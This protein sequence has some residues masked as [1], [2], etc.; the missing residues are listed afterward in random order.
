MP[1]IAFVI[2]AVV[3]LIGFLIW[4]FTR[5]KV[6]SCDRSPPR[7]GIGNGTYSVNQCTGNIAGNG[8]YAG[9]AVDAGLDPTKLCICPK[10][11]NA[12][13][14][15]DPIR[16]PETGWYQWFYDGQPT[17]IGGWGVG[18]HACVDHVVCSD[19][20]FAQLDGELPSTSSTFGNVAK[21]MRAVARVV[22]D[23][24]NPYCPVQYS[25][26]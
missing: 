2:G 18:G 19:D 3:V 14:N 22:A 1:R 13:A 7:D 5:L 4:Y 8:W 12:P 24:A 25:V 15:I 6:D 26:S 11:L 10:T 21:Q 9:P 23:G 20:F 16:G 17:C